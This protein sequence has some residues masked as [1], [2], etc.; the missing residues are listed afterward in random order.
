MGHIYSQVGNKSTGKSIKGPRSDCRASR[1]HRD[2]HGDRSSGKVQR[3]QNAPVL[4][5]LATLVACG[6]EASNQQGTTPESRPTGRDCATSEI[7]CG[8]GR[9]VATIANACKIPITCRLH[10]E[11]LCQTTGG[12]AGPTSAASKE[13]T[14]LGAETRYLEA[15]VSCDGTPV[16]T[17]IESLACE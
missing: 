3:V 14:T 17:R 8:S 7:V 16:T 11:S 12:E 1:L 13:V 4:A 10:I 15:Q 9:C 5:M 2:F 6:A